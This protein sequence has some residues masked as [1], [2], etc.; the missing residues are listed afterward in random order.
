[1][2]SVIGFTSFSKVSGDGIKAL[3]CARSRTGIFYTSSKTVLNVWQNTSGMWGI[4]RRGCKSQT[5]PDGSLAVTIHRT[6]AL[7]IG[8]EGSA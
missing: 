7:R 3:R 4:Q 5:L 6:A 8:F 2:D 1:M